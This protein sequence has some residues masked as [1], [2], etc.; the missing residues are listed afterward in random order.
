MGST[1]VRSL[2]QNRPPCVNEG[3][4]NQQPGS[5]AV[6]WC[7]TD[8]DTGSHYICA[9]DWHGPTRTAAGMLK[10]VGCKRNVRLQLLPVQCMQ[11]PAP[12]LGDC[13]AAQRTEETKE[14]WRLHGYCCQALEGI[15]VVLRPH[16]CQPDLI[17]PGCSLGITSL[18]QEV[19]HW[20]PM[21]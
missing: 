8:L 5:Q 12:H 20:S 19:P 15:A 13:E 1:A 18:Q 14:E 6:F 7:T 16:L 2:N 10:S 3:T 9:T 21:Q 11:R 4:C 17:L